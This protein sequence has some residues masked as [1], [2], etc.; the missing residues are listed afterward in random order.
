VASVGRKRATVTAMRETQGVWWMEPKTGKA[1]NRPAARTLKNLKE[2][3]HQLSIAGRSIVMDVRPEPTLACSG[4]DRN[5]GTL[6]GENRRRQRARVL[7]GPNFIGKL[8]A[9]G[10]LRIPVRMWVS[11]SVARG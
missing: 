11:Y 9:H 10:W 8:Q 2:G 3:S 7:N 6:V 1:A 4:L 5:A